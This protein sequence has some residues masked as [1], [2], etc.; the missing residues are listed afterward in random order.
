MSTGAWSGRAWLAGL[1]LLVG[2]ASAGLACSGAGVVKVFS[3]T[4][5]LVEAVAERPRSHGPAVCVIHTAALDDLTDVPSDNFYVGSPCSPR[6]W[7]GTIIERSRELEC[8]PE[9]KGN[10]GARVAF[11]VGPDGVPTEVTADERCAS[12]IVTAWR[13][14]PEEETGHPPPPRRALTRGRASSAT[15]SRR[16]SRGCARARGPTWLSSGPTRLRTFAVTTICSRGRPSDASAPPRGEP[17]PRRRRSP[18]DRARGP[19]TGASSRPSSTSPWAKA[20]AVSPA[21]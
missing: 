3:V 4:G 2:A 12:D 5:E 8:C 9:A 10:S 6:A 1:A 14:P 19:R 18:R 20:T 21:R 11:T 13:F 16:C 7:L 15:G 17:L